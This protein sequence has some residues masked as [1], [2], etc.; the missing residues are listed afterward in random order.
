[1]VTVKIKGYE[2]DAVSITNSFNRRAIMFKNNIISVLRKI[3][4]T[5]DDIE[6]DIEPVAIRKVPASVSWYVDGF[7]LHYSYKA[8]KNYVENLYVVSKLIELEVKSIL[9]NRKS[10]NE[11][12]SDFTEKE[13]VDE[14]RKAAREL[15]EVDADS[16]DLDRINNNYKRLA[17]NLHPDMPNGDTEKFKALNHAHKILKREL[18]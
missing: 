7:H 18:E 15:L 5:K 9:E 10:M 13:N 11:F 16:L 14:E 12:I 3:G 8:G 1:M 17:K 6:I 2:F 4:L